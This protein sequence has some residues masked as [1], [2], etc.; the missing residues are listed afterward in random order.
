MKGDNA[1]NQD[2]VDALVGI[3]FA[4]TLLSAVGMLLDI[5]QAVYYSV[6]LLVAVFMLIGSLNARNEWSAQHLRPVIAYAVLL[7]ALFLGAGLTLESSG[8]W[9]GVPIST[10]IFL[11]VLW[12]VTAI[13]TPLV[14]AYVYTH[15]LSREIDTD[16]AVEATS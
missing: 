1:M 3:F 5:W 4:V 8:T 14:Y 7:M 2:R 16:G 9:G 15:W 11:Y 13:G 12:P 10:A 6:P